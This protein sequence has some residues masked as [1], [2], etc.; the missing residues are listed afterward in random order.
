M[1]NIFRTFLIAVSASVVFPLFALASGD[2]SVYRYVG[3]DISLLPLYEE[4]GAQ[5]KT[6]DGQPISDVLAFC[7]EEGMN[8]MRV[9]VFVNPEDYDGPGDDPN[10]CQ[11][12]ESVIPLCKRIKDAGLALILDF[13][14][15][16]TWADP[17]KQWTPKQ[18]QGL[19]D[20][21]LCTSVHDYTKE[22]LQKL[23]D[24][25]AVPDFIQTGNEI[26]YGM[27]WGAHNAAQNDLKKTFMGSDNNWARLGQL[28]NSATSAC[29]E[30]CPEAKIIIHTERV[31]Q[32][33]VQRNFYNRMRSLGV[34]YDIIG[35]SYYPYFHGS[36]SVLERAINELE[37]DFPGKN[38][39]VVETG[40]AYAWK[41]PGTNQ[42]VDYPY[43]DAGQ[44]QYARDLVEMLRKHNQV[45][46]LFWWWMEYNAYGTT[47]SGWYN[48]P[49]FDSRTGCATAALTTICSFA[50]G[51]SGVTTVVQDPESG[52]MRLYNIYGQQIDNPSTFKGIMIGS[53]GTK[54]I[55]QQ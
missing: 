41:V 2:G 13:M 20:Q 48:A 30:V 6:H 16:D 29:R 50:E 19:N 25:G 5:Y 11:T 10:A 15:S 8:G 37:T 46:G 53:D 36:M 26:S 35:I 7:K 4:A 18:W 51:N 14:Y 21:Q 23:K 31:A 49:L 28:L 1:K 32:P 47:L 54:I 55:R 43:S 45:D 24:A 22:S 52:N 44:D 34:D 27:L 38:I 39:M 33:D 42:T 17:S 9:R 3:G 12:I 40:Y